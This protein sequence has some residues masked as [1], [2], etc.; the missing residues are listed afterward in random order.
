MHDDD[1]HE[2]P[3]STPNF[4]TEL[5][6]QLAELAPEVIADG[7][8]DVAKLQELLDGDAAEGS[9]RFGLSKLSCGNIVYV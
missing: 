5:A 2:T 3:S 7:K 6:A 4:R 9:E 1:I 8:V